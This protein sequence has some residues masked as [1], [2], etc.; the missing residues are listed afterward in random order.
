MNKQLVEKVWKQIKEEYPNFKYFAMRTKCWMCKEKFDKP[1]YYASGGPRTFSK[2]KWNIPWLIH[3]NQTHGIPPD[4]MAQIV[5]RNE[6][7]TN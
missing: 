3:I 2:G 1:I 7:A 4:I 5:F 6:K